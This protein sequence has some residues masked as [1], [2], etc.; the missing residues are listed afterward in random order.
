MGE[1][2]AVG[3][4]AATPVESETICK[5][6]NLT[7][8]LKRGHLSVRSGD[9]DGVRVFVAV[10]GVGKANAAVASTILVTQF[11]VEHLFSVGIAG[12]YPDSG[13]E[14]G[15]VAIATSETYADEGCLSQDGWLDME[16]LGRPLV[17]VDEACFY[18]SFPLFTPKGVKLPA[19]PFLTLSTVTGTREAS[20]ELMRRFPQALCETM[21]GA[22]V[23]HVATILGVPCTEVRGVSNMVGP[24]DRASWLVEE[25]AEKAQREVLKLIKQ[26]PFQG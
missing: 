6:L 16:A 1:P 5:E 11:Q 26:L 4:V 25:A 18:Q 7:E 21:E 23:A 13:L 22:A 2:V 10:S 24:R 14:P 9:C 19:G 17:E 12:A 8:V 20:Q 15:D 3:V